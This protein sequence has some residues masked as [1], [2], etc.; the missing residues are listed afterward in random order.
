MD[1]YDFCNVM[2]FLLDMVYLFFCVFFICFYL[3]VVIF[4]GILLFVKKKVGFMERF[5]MEIKDGVVGWLL[6]LF[7]VGGMIGFL[8]GV[9]M[10]I[11][12]FCKIKEYD[13][14]EEN[15]EKL[16]EYW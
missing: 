9:F 11:S 16:Y 8:V 1:L 10:G 4:V 5:V 14:E 13:D 3:G 7:L 6:V 12:F 15:V 2:E